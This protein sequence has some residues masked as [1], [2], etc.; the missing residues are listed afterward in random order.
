MVVDV[1]GLSGK[2]LLGKG[3]VGH[4]GT[5]PRTVHGKE[6]KSGARDLI[7]MVVAIGHQLVTA[8]GYCIQAHRLVNSVGCAK[9][10]IRI[11]A[12]YAAAT[13]IE[14]LKGLVAPA[15]FQNVQKANNVR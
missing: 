11:G 12:I 1:D 7:E 10:N 9:W 14:Q 15:C 4:V 13:G 6:A 5:S 8:L 2:D 3:E